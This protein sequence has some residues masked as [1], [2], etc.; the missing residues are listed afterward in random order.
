MMQAIR[1]YLK[2]S[3]EEFVLRT[4]WPSWVSLQKST[5]V[6]ILGSI[7]FAMLVF[8]MD[9]GITTVLDVIYQLFA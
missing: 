5:V 6:V 1:S 2:S 7:I 8:V 3:Y 9:K 4:T